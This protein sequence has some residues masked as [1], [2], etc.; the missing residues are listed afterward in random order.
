MEELTELNILYEDNHIIV[1]EKKPNIVIGV[2][3]LYEMF[4]DSKYINGTD[5]SFAELLVMGGDKISP[6]KLDNINETLKKNNCK[7]KINW[8]D[9]G[10]QMFFGAVEFIH[11]EKVWQRSNEQ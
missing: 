8:N 7:Q 9:G 10:K 6:S 3:R 1:V 4:P 5:L 11:I 2:P